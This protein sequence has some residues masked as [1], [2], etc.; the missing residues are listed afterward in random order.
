MFNINGLSENQRSEIFLSSE[1]SSFQVS[2]IQTSSA[3]HIEG[4]QI[5]ITTDK[6]H[7]I[8][9]LVF[10]VIS[11][12]T[13][14]YTFKNINIYANH[15]DVL[16]IREIGSLGIGDLSTGGFIGYSM[17][18]SYSNIALYLNNG[19]IQSRSLS[20][21][22]KNAQVDTNNTYCGGFIG[23]FRGPNATNANIK[24]DGMIL[25]IKNKWGQ[26]RKS[27]PFKTLFQGEEIIEEKTILVV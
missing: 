15:A 9:G 7:C 4:K 27:N 5:D 6:E 8:A 12:E 2:A 20:Y 24:I 10:G 26:Q 13:F 17:G 23:D 11:K 22:T 21:E 18:T 19:S 16:A 25:K 3:N 14:A 1:Q